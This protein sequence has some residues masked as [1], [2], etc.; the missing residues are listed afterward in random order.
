MHAA[1]T[2]HSYQDKTPSCFFLVSFL[3]CDPELKI[4]M[5]LTDTSQTLK[6]RLWG[7]ATAK[8]AAQICETLHKLFF[9]LLKLNRDNTLT[10][11]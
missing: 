7:T 3:F 6:L 4:E 2:V 1:L 10:Q 11:Q 5:D 8:S 9:K